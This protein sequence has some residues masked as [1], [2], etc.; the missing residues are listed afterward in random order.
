MNSRGNTIVGTG[1][2]STHLDIGVYIAGGTPGFSI[3]ETD[4]AVNGR[5]WD[6][7][8]NNGVLTWR[9]LAD[10][11]SAQTQFLKVTRSGTSV[12]DITLNSTQITFQTYG[13]GTG[14][15]TVGAADSGGA[16][17]KLLR[18]PN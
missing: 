3:Q 7:I 16:G 4:Q 1:V 2:L 8:S 9:T 11:L 15:V 17:F 13:S 10:D 14:I 12:T 18:V 5:V 6:L